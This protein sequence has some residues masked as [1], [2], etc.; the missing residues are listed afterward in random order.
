MGLKGTGIFN[1]PLVTEPYDI[2][3]LTEQ[4]FLH[5]YHFTLM[6]TVSRQLVLP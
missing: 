3:Y 5:S 6:P 4:R 2:L 1:I